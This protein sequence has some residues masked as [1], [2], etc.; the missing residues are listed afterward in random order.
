MTRLLALLLL[1]TSAMAHSWY[2]V[3]CCH[4]NDCRR[5]PCED[6]AET[7]TGYLYDGV[8]FEKSAMQPSRDRWCHVCILEAGSTKR[9]LCL[10]TLQGT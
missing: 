9:G 10:F 2:P 6:I 8:K 5:V 3:N 7:P 1:T 4:D